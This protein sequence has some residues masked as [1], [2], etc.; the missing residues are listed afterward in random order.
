MFHFNL[1]FA[2]FKID[3]T[4]PR[5]RNIW[6][7]KIFDDEPFIKMLANFNL[8]LLTYYLELSKS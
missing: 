4:D 7:N 2:L 6:A 5:V 3:E 8:S 1:A